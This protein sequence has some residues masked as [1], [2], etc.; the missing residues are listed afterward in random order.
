MN[1]RLVWELDGI[2]TRLIPSVVISKTAEATK[3]YLV[4]VSAAFI[5]I[6]FWLIKNYLKL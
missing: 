3:S 1:E 6:F 4:P 2:C 5:A